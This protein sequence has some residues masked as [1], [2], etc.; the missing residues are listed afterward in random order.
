MRFLT[1][2]CALAALLLLALVSSI[3]FLRAAGLPQDRTPVVIELAGQSLRIDPAFVRRRNDLLHRQHEEFELVVVWP[4]LG[5]AAHVLG[6]TAAENIVVISLRKP[7]QSLHPADKPGR[8][9][10]R[11]LAEEVDSLEPGLVLRRFL[12]GSPYEDE[13]VVMTPPEGRSFWVRCRPASLPT[14]AESSCI[15]DLRINQLDVSFRLNAVH[16][17]DWP[18][19]VARLQSLLDRLAQ[20]DM[21]PD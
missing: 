1:C 11:F 20:L 2:A 5:P 12:S 19:F 18:I 14:V 4:H 10:V 16:L 15:G 17:K 13:A 7:D 8:L 3:W 6:Q 21:A 9:Y